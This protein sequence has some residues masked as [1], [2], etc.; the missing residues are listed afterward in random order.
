[1]SK[2]F[3]TND[4]KDVLQSQQGLRSVRENQL[5][6]GENIED[7]QDKFLQK[8]L[9]PGEKIRPASQDHSKGEAERRFRKLKQPAIP[10]R[11]QANYQYE[12]TNIVKLFDSYD[13]V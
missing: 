4:E 10:Y 12:L 7:L 3:L 8:L 11:R 2:V 1:M 5:Q 6:N 13:L 9:E